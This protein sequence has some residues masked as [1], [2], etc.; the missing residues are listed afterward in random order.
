MNTDSKQNFEEKIRLT[1]IESTSTLEEEFELML[2]KHAAD[3]LIRSGNTIKATMNI[4]TEL[5]ARI[6][7]EILSYI[8][9]LDLKYSPSLEN[10]ISKLAL[11]AQQ[12][13]KIEAI[14]KL[15]KST[16]IA[17]NPKL[18]E[19]MLPEVEADMAN[20]LATFRNNL[21]AKMLELRQRTVKSPIERTLWALEFICFAISIFV[22]GMWFNDPEGNYEPFLVGLSSA[23]FLVLLIIK[24][25]GKQ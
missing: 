7:S 14:A 11:D 16:E 24:R 18:F 12:K 23:M 6:Y 5:T 19:R 25:I 22:A 2:R 13:F 3:G 10:D 20:S 4:I 9:A 21:N 15:D 1:L 8:D 17:G